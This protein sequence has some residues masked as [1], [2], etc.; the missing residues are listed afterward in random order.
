MTDASVGCRRWDGLTRRTPMVET[1]D[2]SI[3]PTPGRL[4]LTATGAT[5]TPPLVPGRFLQT[6]PDGRIVEVHAF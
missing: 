2:Q 6:D 1:D 4:G 5:A 3:V